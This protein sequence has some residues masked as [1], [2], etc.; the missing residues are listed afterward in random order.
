MKSR[1][2]VAFKPRIVSNQD[3][4]ITMQ[5][6]IFKWQFA[7]KKFETICYECNHRL[8]GRRGSGSLHPCRASE[9]G[10]I[11]INIKTYECSHRLNGRRGSV[12]LHPYRA[13]ELRDIGVNAN[14][15]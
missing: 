2:V 9:L 15:S 14:L 8:I 4:R 13:S 6:N 7:R 3:R 11:R 5:L 12:S 1:S 10:D